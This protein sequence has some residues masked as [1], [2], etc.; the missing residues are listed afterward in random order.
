MPARSDNNRRPANGCAASVRDSLIRARRWISIL[1]ALA[2]FAPVFATGA[3]ALSGSDPFL[4]ADLSRA[5][6]E[7]NYVPQANGEYALF[8]FSRDGGAV[9]AEA[10]L[11]QNGRE[12]ASGEGSGRLFSLWLAADTQYTVRVKGTGSAVIE[13]ARNTFSRSYENPM[14]AEENRLSEKMIAR[15]YDAHWYRFRAQANG[16]MLLSCVPK[17]GDMALNA[18]LFDANG[19]MIANFGSLSGGGRMLIANTVKDAD[20]YLRV[21]AAKGHTG[22]YEL[23][24]DRSDSGAISSALRFDGAEFS[25]AAAGSA[26]LNDYVQGE[27]MLW[28]S[29]RPDI[30]SVDQNGVVYGHLPGTAEI[31]VYGVNSRASCRVNVEFIEMQGMDIIAREITLAEGDDTSV[32]IE[33]YPENTSERN[34]RFLVEDPSVA[35]ITPDGVLRGKKTG[36]TVLHAYGAGGIEDSVKIS[37]IPA[38]RK[39][40]ALLVS[41]ENYLYKGMR[42]GSGTSARAIESL[43]T[44]FEFENA[45]F[46]TDLRS[47]LSRGE[48]LSAIRE[49]F[50]GAAPADVSLFYITCHGHYIGGMSFLELSDGSFVAMRDIER[51]LRKIP[52]T[53]VVVID[54]CASG[55]A[56]GAYSEYEKFARGV[57]GEFAAAPVNG[58]KYKVICSA[59][60]DQDSFRLALNEDGGEGVMATL[61]ARAL[62]DGAGWSIDR[63]RVSSMGADVN[64]DGRISIGELAG[65]M[66]GRIDWYLDIVE[67][68]TGVRYRQDIQ[69]YPEGDPLIL[70]DRSN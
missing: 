60:L 51:E 54:C 28:A 31:T 58:S 61:F 52:G 22:M 37:V 25:V 10:V 45:A 40:R 32:E 5:Q 50:S 70:V 26:V 11:L 46:I 42:T 7:F 14:D 62:C 34:I 12:I 27:A 15:A 17:D 57:T 19:A 20:Y 55:G 39:Y 69:V 38:V 24:L 9:S 68:K 35:E 48:L 2:V 6:F 63:S 8:L 1:L 23:R 49:S 66:Q 44:S 21:S 59:G 67:E 47:D 36:E 64:Y 4:Y 65:Y 53:V 41:E 33:F 56:I 13:M 3:F 43:L 30:A 18:R 29:D 16:R